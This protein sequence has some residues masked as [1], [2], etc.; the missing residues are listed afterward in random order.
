[1]PHASTGKSPALLF[2]NREIKTKIDRILPKTSYV[3]SKQEVTD[4]QSRVLDVGVRVAARNYNGDKWIFGRVGNVLGKLHYLI[5]LDNGKF[6]KRH[7]D[8]VRV[9][10]ENIQKEEHDD[11]IPFPLIASQQNLSAPKEH[12]AMGNSG[13]D[14]VSILPPGNNSKQT[15]VKV[16]RP[17]NL[18]IPD[19]RR[20]NRI[21]KPVERLDL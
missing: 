9:I 14:S 19:I 3:L 16:A 18:T 11:S 21:R 1:M 7:I 5:R 4:N 15:E 17:E 20:S 8:Q 13:D 10:G 12:S 6:I 2:L